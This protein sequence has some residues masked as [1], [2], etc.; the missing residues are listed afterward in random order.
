[1][2]PG[3]DQTIY[4]LEQ[5]TFEHVGRA[6]VLQQGQQ[7]QWGLSQGR[8]DCGH[9]EDKSINT[10]M[11]PLT[12]TGGDR[13]Y[14]GWAA[15]KEMY[16]SVAGDN[17]QWPPCLPLSSE[18]M[19]KTILL[20]RQSHSQQRKSAGGGSDRASPPNTESFPIPL[21]LPAQSQT[22]GTQDQCPQERTK[23][24]MNHM[25]S[26]TQRHCSTPPQVQAGMSVS[27]KRNRPL[28][29]GLPRS[30]KPETLGLGVLS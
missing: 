21:G 1:M 29:P 17:H 7:A 15:D 18:C 23:G 30:T 26:N 22:P 12:K 6:L 10:D 13:S 5:D 19:R 28:L 11:S 14:Q 27:R 20:P 3:H 2:P 9:S 24:T 8:R 25:G 16:T 4:P